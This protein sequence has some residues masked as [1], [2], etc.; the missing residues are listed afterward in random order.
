MILRSVARALRRQDWA[1]VIIEFIVVVAGIFVALQVDNWN[2]HRKDNISEQVF[3]GRLAADMQWNIENFLDLQ[4]IFEG[5]ARF[6][7]FLR[8]VPA[9][10]LMLDEPGEF[11][12]GLRHSGYVSLPS[13]RSATFTELQN[14]GQISLL[15]DVD[16]RSDLSTFYAEYQLMQTILD[17]PVGDYRRMVWETVPGDVTHK[18]QLNDDPDIEAIRDAVTRLQS[19]PRFEAAANAEIAYAT[20]LVYWLRVRRGDAERILVAINES[21]TR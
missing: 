12:R 3:L 14:S 1:T 2:Q 8:E 18:W 4:T 11:L 13:V 19:D 21:M 15:R 10:Q 20:D 16:L 6:I 7:Q 5:K 9:S 17:E